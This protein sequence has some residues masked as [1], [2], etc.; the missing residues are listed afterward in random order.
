MFINLLSTFG[1]CNLGRHFLMDPLWWVE[2]KSQKLI[3]LSQLHLNP[4]FEKE[5]LELKLL[6]HTSFILNTITIIEI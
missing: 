3:T 2:T 4:T 5:N 6:N 1:I